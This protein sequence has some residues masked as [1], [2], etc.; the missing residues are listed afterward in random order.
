MFA[1]VS[2]VVGYVSLKLAFSSELLA[3]SIHSLQAAPRDRLSDCCMHRACNIYIPPL[4]YSRALS[5]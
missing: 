1:G 5:T 3:S 2:V 4:Q